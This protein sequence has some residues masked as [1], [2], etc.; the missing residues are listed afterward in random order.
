[1]PSVDRDI[2]GRATRDVQDN[3]PYLTIFNARWA[4]IVTWYNVTF[5]GVSEVPNPVTVYK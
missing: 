4:L 2:L 1:L 5:Y 3:F